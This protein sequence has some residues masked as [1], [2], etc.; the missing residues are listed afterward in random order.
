MFVLLGRGEKAWQRDR[1][2]ERERQ[3]TYLKEVVILTRSVGHCSYKRQKLSEKGLKHW[4][5][6]NVVRKWHWRT[7]GTSIYRTKGSWYFTTSRQSATGRLQPTD[8]NKCMWSCS[9][10]EGYESLYL[11]YFI[12]NLGGWNNSRF[13]ITYRGFVFVDAYYYDLSSRAAN[14]DWALETNIQGWT[15]FGRSVF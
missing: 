9:L 13:Y 8:R 7:L 6:Q 3:G 1:E 10:S 11:R 14:I 15:V 12:W 2:K 4:C 5:T